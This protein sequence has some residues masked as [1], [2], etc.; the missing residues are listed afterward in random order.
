[1][2]PI[3]REYDGKFFKNP[4]IQ[5]FVRTVPLR[6]ENYEAKEEARS[7]YTSMVVMKASML[8]LR[9]VISANQLSIY[10]AAADLCN[11]VHQDLRARVK[12]AALDHLDKMELPSHILPKKLQPMHGSGDTWCEQHTSHVIFSQCCTTND[13]HTRGSSRK[14][15]VRTHI[16]IS[17]RSCCVFDSLRL[18]HFLFY[19]VYLLSYHLVFPPGHQLHL[20]RCGGQIPCALQLMRTLPLL[21]STTVSQVMCQRLPH[22]G[23]YGI[24][25]PGI[26]RR[27][28][29]PE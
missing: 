1:M 21:P 9:T 7:Q 24:V 18:H 2:E 4:V 10:R 25:H 13:T 12:L 29:V 16:I 23:G 15:G 11:E 14:F 27:V 28:R 26:L 22:L 20:P 17:M 8:L 3:S 6:E 5:Y 19:A